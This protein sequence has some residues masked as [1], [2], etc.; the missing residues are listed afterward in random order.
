[1]AIDS[2]GGSSFGYD[3]ETY[4]AQLVTAT[5]DRLNGQGAGDSYAITDKQ[6]FGAAVVSKT[7]DYMN[8]GSNSSSEMAQNYSFSKDILAGYT[9]GKGG[10]A[11]Y[12]I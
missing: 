1:M 5:L 8:S 3:K 4:G 11:D 6:S 7:L 2:L 10:F 9:V 12:N